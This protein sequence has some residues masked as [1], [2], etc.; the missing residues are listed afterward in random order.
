MLLSILFCCL[1]TDV[2]CRHTLG[3]KVPSVLSYKEGQA[4]R[5]KKVVRYTA[6]APLNFQSTVFFASKAHSMFV[7]QLLENLSCRIIGA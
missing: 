1:F 4:L 2:S 7:L 6:F 3:R 5:L